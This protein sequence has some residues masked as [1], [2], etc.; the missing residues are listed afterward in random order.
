MYPD[1]THTQ[2]SLRSLDRTRQDTRKRIQR[3][4]RE[5]PPLTGLKRQHQ[6]RTC[7]TC[8]KE[9]PQSDYEAECDHAPGHH[10][11]R[12]TVRHLRDNQRPVKTNLSLENQFDW[13]GGGSLQTQ[14][15]LA[16]AAHIHI[17]QAHRPQT[18]GLRDQ[19]QA[20]T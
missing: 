12:K 5:Y 4:S 15:T 18:A 10:L 7:P 3:A 20:G 1:H 9:P 14:T 2:R 11:T 6:H 13:C 17:L 8:R 19:Y 16:N